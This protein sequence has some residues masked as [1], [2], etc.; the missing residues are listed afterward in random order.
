M[1]SEVLYLCTGIVLVLMAA[2]HFLSMCHGA[3]ERSWSHEAPRHNALHA[4]SEPAIAYWAEMAL[5]TAILLFGFWIAIS[6][7]LS[8]YSI[9]S[10]LY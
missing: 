8:L 6:A 5:C 3:H 7:G 1:A 9:A 10:R 4:I 2:R